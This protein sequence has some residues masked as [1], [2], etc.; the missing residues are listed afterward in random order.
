MNT[1]DRPTS[2]TNEVGRPAALRAPENSQL[3]RREQ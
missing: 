1:G 2:T 3:Q